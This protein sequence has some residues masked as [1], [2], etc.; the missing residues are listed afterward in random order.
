VSQPTAQT[1][2][3][4]AEDDPLLRGFLTRVLEGEADF[5]VL[6]SVGN[7]G[8]VLAEV[9][10]LQPQILLLDVNLPGLSGLRVLQ[11]LAARGDGP[12]TLM[13]SGNEDEGTQLEAARSGA[14]GFLCKSQ[15]LGTLPEVVRKVAAG[16]V[17]F[18]PR[19]VGQI[20]SDYPAYVRKVRDQEKPLNQLSDREREVL[21]RVAQGHTNQQIASELF[22]SVSTVKVHLRNIFSKLNIAN[23]TDAA[24]FAVREGLL[25][26]EG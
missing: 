2:L 8:E 14:R 15:A 17:W 4:I 12:S 18:A 20:V 26:G 24:V 13:L 19:I 9:E 25:G 7:G 1:T 16:E 3:L 23:R 11:Q 21:V 6:G 22:M 5:R 10:R